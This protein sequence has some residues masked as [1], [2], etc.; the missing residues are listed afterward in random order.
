VT[1]LAMD[2]SGRSVESLSLEEKFGEA[3]RRSLPLMPAGVA[4]EVRELLEPEALAMMVAVSGAWAVSH[5]FGVGEI[6]DGVLLVM[7]WAAAGGAAIGM[8]RDLLKAI[9]LIRRARSDADLDAAARLFASVAVRMGATA[10][11]AIF[12]KG[13][14]KIYGGPP[15][16]IPAGPHGGSGLFYKPTVKTGL[17]A[18]PA[19]GYVTLGITDEF[20]DIT[21][22]SSL[23]RDPAKYLH[24]LF[25]ERVHQFL[26]PKLYPLR[27]VRV[28]LAI[29]G[30]TKSYIL[31]YLEEALAQ[32]VA[33]LRMYRRGL[34]DAVT[35]PVK[36]GYCTV[37]DM[38]T[39]VR[40]HLMGVINVSG[41]MYK[42][43]FT[44]GPDAVKTE[45][46]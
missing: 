32:A 40:G 30:Y 42:V 37:A 5:F 27:Q 23:L 3:I 10:L 17:L 31:R 41:M 15:P 7:G 14:P 44:S 19:P 9:N 43:L 18:A 25:H 2:F 35:F 20:G 22:H 36:N 39:E 34:L 33:N 21:I 16:R 28:K 8:G 11:S 38:M 29:G 4:A 26:T 1:A 24:T 6:A 46:R 12:F 45:S 13:R